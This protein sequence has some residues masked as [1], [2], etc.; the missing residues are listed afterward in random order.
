MCLQDDIIFAA[1]AHRAAGPGAA[2]QAA[3][4]ASAANNPAPSANTAPRT[5]L[6]SPT[7]VKA[8]KA[9]PASPEASVTASSQSKPAQPA[10]KG[11]GHAASI[12]SIS[13]PANVA[14][15]SMSGDGANEAEGHMHAASIPPA[16]VASETTSGDPAGEAKSHLHAASIPP[17]DAP[18][19]R[20]MGSTPSDTAAQVQGHASSTGTTAAPAAVASASFQ[21]DPGPA[22]S[23]AGSTGASA[24]SLFPQ[25]VRGTPAPL[26]RPHESGKAA[27][28]DIAVGKSELD[29]AGSQPAVDLLADEQSKFDLADAA[30]AESSPA[31]QAARVPQPKAPSGVGLDASKSSSNSSTDAA[32]TVIHDIPAVSRLGR[33]VSLPCS[34]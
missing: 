34:A 12:P 3:A 21:T 7:P 17:P 18:A 33:A 23:P 25:T 2:P 16:N 15:E 13:A 29:M 6:A 28:T 1:A 10:S 32:G 19:A 9:A 24:L 8:V 31:E 14:F 20:P 11:E 26:L 30:D 5:I 27:G 4:S 22:G